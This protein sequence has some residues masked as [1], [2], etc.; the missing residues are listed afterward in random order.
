[1][2]I[3]NIPS[4]YPFSMDDLLRAAVDRGCSDLHLV[5]GMAPCMRISGEMLPQEMPIL[6]PQDV[7]K[8]LFEVLNQ[9]QIDELMKQWELDFS[10]SV[11]G[12]ARFRGNVIV[13]RGTLAVVYR[14]VPFEVPAIEALGLPDDVRRLATLTRGL[15]LVT[16]P[17]GSGKST[18]MA[19]LINYINA[20]RAVNIVTIEDPIEFLHKHNKATVRQR[21]VGTDTHSFSLALRQAL[22]HDPDI[23]MIGEMRD[24]ESISI[25]LTAAETGHLV[26][27]T[28]HTQTAPLSISRIVDSFPNEGKQQVRQQLSGSLRAILSQQLVRTIDGKRVA[29]TEYMIDIPAVR[30]MIRDGKENQLYS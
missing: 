18:S 22:R 19:A 8:L 14:V 21:E 17:T 25:A 3:V 28:L 27:S 7:Q 23:I 4:T 9:E 10:Y 13:Q 29:A 12:Y 15:I 5:V 11:V 26:I 16:G 24:L 6:L 30:A 1:M 20:T 2:H